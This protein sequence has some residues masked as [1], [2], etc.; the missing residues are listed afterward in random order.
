[1]KNSPE[2]F[3]SLFLIELIISV[4]FVKS[5]FDLYFYFS[6]RLLCLYPKTLRGNIIIWEIQGPMFFFKFL[7]INLVSVEESDSAQ[8][9]TGRSQTPA[10]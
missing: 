10:V 1:M 4:L 7:L 5:R 3:P 6:F 8:A 9:N 2:D